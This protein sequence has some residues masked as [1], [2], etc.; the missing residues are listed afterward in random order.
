MV[1]KKYLFAFMVVG[2][3]FL[4]AAL[5]GLLHLFTGHPDTPVGW[6]VLLIAT[7][8][9]LLATSYT[10]WFVWAM[11]RAKERTSILGRLAEGDLTNA[12]Y[13][14][15]GDQREVRRLIYS[16]RRALTQVQRVTGNVRRTCQGVSEEV[17]V[18]LDAARRQG[19]A[20][21]RS[22]ESVNS[23]GQSLQAAGKR[24]TQLESFAQETNG[25]LMEM[26]ER[27][28]QVAEALLAL[29]EFS[30]RTTQQVQAMSERLH[31]IASSG[32]ELARFANEA[33][34]FV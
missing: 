32:D 33:E 25:S 30:H 6:A 1:A 20:V 24:V 7:P 27:L 18:L 4:A 11:E 22:Q 15:M 3:L 2:G 31:H 29:D 23:M 12:V 19:G 17:R 21:E 13:D 5:G 10:F 16:L 34:A 9:L 8:L 26:A 28:G 14:G